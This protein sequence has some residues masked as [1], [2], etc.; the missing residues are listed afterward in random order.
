MPKTIEQRVTFRAAPE[1]LY[2]IYMDARKHAAAIGST[3]VLERRVSGWFTAFGE[4]LRGRNLALV[5]GH[6]I[7]Q[8]WRGADWTK[9]DL[10]SLLVLAFDRARGGGRIHL[11]H[12]HVPDRRAAGIRRGWKK[13][14]WT[15]WKA[16]LRRAAR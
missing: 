3:V 13:Y 1:R 10:D 4:M 15:P 14:Y 16:Y 8:T 6:L 9:S 2:D 5:P 7:V 12:A 11:V